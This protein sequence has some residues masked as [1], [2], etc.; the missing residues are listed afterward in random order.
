[1]YVCVYVLAT[2]RM[3]P[4]NSNNTNNRNNVTAAN[5][6]E[7][8]SNLFTIVDCHKN[9]YIVGGGDRNARK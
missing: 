6:I 9:Q 3:P 1:M 5:T 4:H 7:H 8:Q 2:Y